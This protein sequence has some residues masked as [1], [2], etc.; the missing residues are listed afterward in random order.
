MA[1]FIPLYYPYLLTYLLTYMGEYPHLNVKVVREHAI[2]IMPQSLIGPNEPYHSAHSG[3]YAVRR[4]L[5]LPLPIKQGIMIREKLQEM[6][7]YI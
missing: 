4:F 6:A 2:M 7:L 3:P 1:I 5:M